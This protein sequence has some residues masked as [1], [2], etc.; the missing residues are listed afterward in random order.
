MVDTAERHRELVAHFAADGPLGG[1]SGTGAKI[2]TASEGAGV[3]FVDENGGGPGVRLREPH[4]GEETQLSAAAISADAAGIA[5]GA[6]LA[7]FGN[8]TGAFA[9]IAAVRLDLSEGSHCG[10]A[11]NI[12]F[13]LAFGPRLPIGRS[14]LAFR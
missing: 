11:A 13:V 9:R 14:R 12:G 5:A 6:L 2:Q 4:C 1:R 8:W 3:E 7:F 10:P